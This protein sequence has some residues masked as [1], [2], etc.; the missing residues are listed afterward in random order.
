MKDLVLVKME[1]TWNEAQSVALDRKEWRWSVAQ[2]I[3]LDAR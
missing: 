2:C 1:L 3:H